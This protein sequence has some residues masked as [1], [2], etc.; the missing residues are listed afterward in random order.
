MSFEDFGY[1][2]DRG[3]SP[4]K[5]IAK[6][7][8]LIGAVFFSIA[9]FFYIT[10]NAYYFVYH[11]EEENS[12]KVIE[13]PKEAIKVLSNSDDGEVIKG[14]DKT[15]YDSMVGNKNL[16]KED[17]NKVKIIKKAATPIAKNPPP[18]K[19]VVEKKPVKKVVILKS[20]TNV[21]TST[22]TQNKISRV[23]L[24]AL[25]SRVS[26]LN[27]WNALQVKNSGLFN[28]LNHFINKA[29]LGSR[30][31]FYRLQIGEFKNKAAAESFCSKFIAQ[32]RKTKSSCINVK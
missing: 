23:Q 28:G 17:L 27:Y 26:A 12:I 10:V 20:K 30:G 3:A 22:I 1:V 18:K 7:S 19:K 15:I 29:D 31:T 4:L 11:D 13:S 24:A 8:L 21:K 14:I 6:K 9:C 25:T 2:K 32:T 5:A 16:Q